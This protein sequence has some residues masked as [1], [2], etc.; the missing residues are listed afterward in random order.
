MTLE[1]SCHLGSLCFRCHLHQTNQQ[2]LTEQI[3]FRIIALYWPLQCP[4]VVSRYLL[5]A[6]STG[7]QPQQTIGFASI[8]KGN[9]DGQQLDKCVTGSRN[10]DAKLCSNTRT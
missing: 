7:N 2:T 4:C 6:S 9:L 5:E 3:N 10:R 8:C 1:E